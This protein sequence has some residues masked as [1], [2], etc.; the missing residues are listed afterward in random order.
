MI[1]R[2]CRSHFLLKNTFFITHQKP[3]VFKPKPVPLKTPPAFKPKK[4]DMS[5]SVAAERL[6]LN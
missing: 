5:L 1:E 6:N 3:S 4:N 2:L